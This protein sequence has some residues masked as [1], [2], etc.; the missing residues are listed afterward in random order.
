[1]LGW[2]ATPEAI[3]DIHHQLGLDRPLVKQY[4]HWIGGAIHGDLG[5]VAGAAEGPVML[6]L[7]ESFPVTIELAVLAALIA[8][9]VAVP[10]AS[11]PPIAPAR[12]STR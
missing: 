4:G 10:R 7:R 6:R 2:E 12:V 9:V 8:L 5:R 3:R 1:M 11:S